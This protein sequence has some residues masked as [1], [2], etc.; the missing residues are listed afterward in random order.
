[1]APSISS[2][3]SPLPDNDYV[4]KLTE[5]QQGA[6]KELKSMLDNAGYSYNSDL[7]DLV[8]FLR[9]RKFDPAGA[10]TQ[11]TSAA[12][13]RADAQIDHLYDTFPLAEFEQGGKLY[14]QWTGRVDK[15]GTPVY[16]FAINALTTEGTAEW[17]QA[18]QERLEER[19]VALCEHMEQ[20][21][22]PFCSHLA[23]HPVTGCVTIADIS[24]VSLRRFW[25][26]KEHMQRAATLASAHYPERLDGM[27]IVG[28]PSFFSTMFGRVK[29]YFDPGTVEKIHILPSSPST[30]HS[31]LTQQMP[32][33]SIPRAYTGE[34]DWTFGDFPA[35]DEAMVAKLGGRTLPPGPVRWNTQR[36]RVVVVGEGR[37]E[38]S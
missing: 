13:W 10:F 37:G 28:A 9:A 18:G 23:G 5:P 2:T 25:Q 33:S 6:L 26:L 24:G 16:V 21:V 35:L 17:A 29:R 19:M 1:M 14:T 36:G 30:I 32:A 31:S 4:A 15:N 7:V 20:F 11:F 38:D 34:L 3:S 8:R 22:L 12:D 27:F